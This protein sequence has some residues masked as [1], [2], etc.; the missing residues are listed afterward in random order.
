ML[1]ARLTT[2]KLVLLIGVLTVIL[3]MPTSIWL[4]V[5]EFRGQVCSVRVTR[6]SVEAQEGDMSY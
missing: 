4:P 1:Q 2:G 3:V 5:L 6:P